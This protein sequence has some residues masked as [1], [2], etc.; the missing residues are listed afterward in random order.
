MIVLG[1]ARVESL[2][3]EV[4][5]LRLSISLHVPVIQGNRN[6]RLRKLRYQLL[7]YCEGCGLC[8]WRQALIATLASRFTDIWIEVYT[9]QDAIRL[10]SCNG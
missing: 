3:L 6:V 5:V 7:I 4:V 9:D 10:C 1:L 2:Q 8:N